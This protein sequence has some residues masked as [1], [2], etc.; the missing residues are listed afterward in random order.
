MEVLG[1]QIEREDVGEQG[2][3]AGANL[4]NR[5]VAEIDCRV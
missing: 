3:Q 4:F 1:L 2:S 5:I